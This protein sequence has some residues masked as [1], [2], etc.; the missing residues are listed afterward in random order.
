MAYTSGKG[1]V[2]MRDIWVRR[3]AVVICAA[4]ALGL[5]WLILRYGLPLLLPFLI[6]WGIALGVVPLGA[7]MA[8]RTHL[9]RRL[10]GGVILTLVLLLVALLLILG[11]NRL[12]V[13]VQRLIGWLGSGGGTVLAARIGAL[14]DAVRD[15]FADLPFAEVLGGDELAGVWGSVDEIAAGLI[16]EAVASLGGMLPAMIASLLRGLPSFLLFLGVTVIAAY[17]FCLDL[18]AIHAA[19]SV[20]LP[21]GWLAR[22][23]ALRRQAAGTVVRWLRAYLLL[24]GLTF[25]ELFVG[26]SLLGIE[27]ALLAASLTAVVDLLPVFGVGTVLIPWG[28]GAM[29]AGDPRLGAGLLILYGVVAIVRQ[30]AEPRIVG[31]SIGLHPLLTLFAMYIGWKWLG[32]WGLLLS[33]AAALAVGLFVGRGG[34]NCKHSS[35]AI[36]RDAN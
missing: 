25:G 35:H 36:D 29:L 7:R 20:L 5:G 12:I 32:L 13:E 34:D 33:P 10:C 26:F 27:Y 1:G 28:I 11:V 14:T 30:V 16:A 15:F 3:A 24:L 23:P 21:E 4:G 2:R 8:E 19:L 18:P 31:G 9:S 22:I 6:G 17:Y